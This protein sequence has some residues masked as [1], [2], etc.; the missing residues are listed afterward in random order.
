MTPRQIQNDAAAWSQGPLNDS[1]AHFPERSKSFATAR[2]LRSSGSTY[3]TRRSW[4]ATATG[5]VS[6]ACFPSLAAPSDYVP[7][8][9][10]DDAG[11]CRLF[12]RRGNES[13]LSLSTVSG[14]NRLEYRVRSAHADR[15]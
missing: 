6:P 1:M 8:P 4:I 3:P 12:H 13:A 7:E 5:S 11:I 2:A 15:P 9:A 14:I 10:M